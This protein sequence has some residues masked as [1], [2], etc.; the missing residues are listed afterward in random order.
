M[1]KYNEIMEMSYRAG[2][3]I[4][5]AK[6]KIYLNVFKAHFDN[7]IRI[8]NKRIKKDMKEGKIRFE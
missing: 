6:D 7:D 4:G 8:L 3:V 2:K 1:T 5:T